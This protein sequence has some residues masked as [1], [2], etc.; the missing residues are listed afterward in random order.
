MGEATPTVSPGAAVPDGQRA[1]LGSVLKT[2]GLTVIAATVL[3]IAHN[4]WLGHWGSVLS[5]LSADVGLAAALALNR[6]GRL[7][8]AIVLA[9]VTLQACATA[10]IAFGGEGVHDVSMMIFPATLVVAG[11]LLGTRGLAWTTAA[12]IAAVTTLGLAERAGWMVTS[13]SGHTNERTL[14]DA[15]I[16][17]AVTAVAVG[18]LAGSLKTSLQ[19]AHDNERRLA[20]ANAE[21]LE[22]ARELAA[23]EAELRQAQKMEVVGR[24]ASG[25]AHDFNNVLMA[26]RSSAAVAARDLVEGSRAGRCL[27]EIDNASEHAAA[28]TR[29]LLALARQQEGEPKRVDLPRLLG[30]LRPLL[31]WLLGSQVPLE[32]TTPDVP[33]VVE[34]DPLQIE[35]VLINLAMNARDA[36][37]RGGR[38]ALEVACVE[39]D[40]AAAAAAA[41][42]PGAHVA[43]TVADTGCGMSQAVRARA[44]DPFFTTK[45]H[46][47]GLGLSIVSG[48]VRRSGGVIAV[49]SQ[50]GRGAMFRILLPRAEGDAT[51]TS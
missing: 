49:E 17:L 6:V 3:P 21:L 37:P 18:L 50:P 14:L 29:R 51:A 16:V 7:A 9:V 42:A 20:A 8:P 32:I 38:V 1:A 13:L 36:M 28:L 26:I 25:I 45:E 35:Q 5:L 31:E 46:G 40:A 47:T 27:A 15:A 24:L 33:A 44:F 10:L 43:L 11:L 48:A 23:S 39:L 22:R 4:A 12:T 2:I 30:E 41:T 19:R 34:V